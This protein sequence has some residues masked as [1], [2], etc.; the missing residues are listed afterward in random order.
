MESDCE[1]SI[2][3]Y[4]TGPIMEGYLNLDYEGSVQKEF[5]NLSRVVDTRTAKY[6]LSWRLSVL[7]VAILTGMVIVTLII[8]I[9]EK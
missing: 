2:T 4:Q 9:L 7:S 8:S 3:I 5:E 1:T 6:R